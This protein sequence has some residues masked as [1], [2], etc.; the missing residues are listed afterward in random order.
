MIGQYRRKP[1]VISA[2]K[3]NGRNLREI[4]RF[5]GEP[6]PTATRW[7][8]YAAL[9]KRDG[10]KLFTNIGTLRASIGDFFI[11]EDSGGYHVCGPEVFKDTYERV[12][13]PRE[14]K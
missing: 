7:K 3:W 9:V 4:L 12:R 5:L 11:Q 8:H 2:V 1:V 10:F 14:K 6:I 13:K